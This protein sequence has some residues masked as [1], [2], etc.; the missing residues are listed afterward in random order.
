MTAGVPMSHEHAAVLHIG[1]MKTGSS[2]LQYGLTWQPVR[3][4]L[5]SDSVA[6]EYVSLLPWQLVR[7]TALQEHAANFAAYY[8]MSDRIESLVGQP[9]EGLAAGLAGLEA[10]RREGRVPILSYETW[11][12]AKPTDVRSFTAALGGPIRVVAY[13]RSPVQWLASLYYQRDYTCEP[14]VRRFLAKWL[15]KARWAD[16]IETWRSA[17]G[18]AA[19]DVRLHGGDICADFCRLL[20]CEPSERRIQHNQAFPAEAIRLLERHPLPSEV[21]LSE[22]KFALWRWLPDSVI[23]AGTLTPAPFPFDQPMISEIIAGSREASRRL[24]GMVDAD[25][26]GR[27]EADPR[28]WSD[29]AVHHLPAV[30]ATDG[31]PHAA[32]ESEALAAALWQ[33]LLAADAA[34]LQ[35]IKP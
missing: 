27:M 25:T 13:V 31:S 2:A 10:V 12:T 35:S 20:C 3:R 8:S 11:L 4:S 28:W 23:Q 6:Y 29:D 24:L 26:R 9:A 7:G 32:H 18:V 15:P 33:C 19:V 21:S 1:S 22:A 5:G 34:W 16:A 30:A 17:P 14:D